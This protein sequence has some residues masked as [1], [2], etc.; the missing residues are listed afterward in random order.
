MSF[1][2]VSKSGKSKRNS[3]DQGKYVFVYNAQGI[4]T[5]FLECLFYMI[6]RIN[7]QQIFLPSSSIEAHIPYSHDSFHWQSQSERQTDVH[8]DCPEIISCK[9]N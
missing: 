2:I 7:F 3:L 8:L 1:C 9:N 4:M 5:S 6:S